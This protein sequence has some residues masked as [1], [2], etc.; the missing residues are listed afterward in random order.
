MA[1]NTNESPDMALA[2]LG[3]QALAA[4][5]LAKAVK[6]AG[7]VEDTVIKV[8][9][10]D[11]GGVPYYAGMLIGPGPDIELS[12]GEGTMPTWLFHPLDVDKTTGTIR[13]VN[14]GAV[15][16]VICSANLDAACKRAQALKQ[17]SAD[18]SGKTKDVS[19]AIAFQGVGKNRKGLPLNMFKV[20]NHVGSVG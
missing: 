14:K 1:K 11:T 12:D 3:D 13:G 2:T 7:F 10:P 5:T 18:G 9:N 4:D 16:T 19:M 6:S 20:F 17:A 8:G 15:H